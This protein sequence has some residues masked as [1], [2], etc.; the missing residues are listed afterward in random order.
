MRYTVCVDGGT[1][2]LIIINMMKTHFLYQ[3][4]KVDYE[5]LNLSLTEFYVLVKLTCSHASHHI[6]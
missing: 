3:H 2:E 4:L 6:D 1:D 5:V